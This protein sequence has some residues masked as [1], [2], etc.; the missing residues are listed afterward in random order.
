MAF[1]NCDMIPSFKINNSIFGEQ[2]DDK[3]ILDKYKIYDL[4]ILGLL[5]NCQDFVSCNNDDSLFNFLTHH[6]F[7][8]IYFKFVEKKLFLDKFIWNGLNFYREFHSLIYHYFRN[9]YN[10][11]FYYA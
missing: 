7:F 9:E 11:S 10:F 6:D 8:S 3:S 5:L 4:P 1:L 2:L